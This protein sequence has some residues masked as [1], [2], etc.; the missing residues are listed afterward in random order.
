M[1]TPKDVVRPTTLYLC[2]HC[3]YGRCTKDLIPI[4]KSPLTITAHKGC[5]SETSWS[6]CKANP[7][8]TLLTTEN[9]THPLILPKVYKPSRELK[10]HSYLGF[11]LCFGDLCSQWTLVTSVFGAPV[12]HAAGYFFNKAWAS[13]ELGAMR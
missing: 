8:D 9:P 12:F 3:N 5:K 13:Q 2:P 6:S 10:P 4:S 7:S 11:Q 1:G